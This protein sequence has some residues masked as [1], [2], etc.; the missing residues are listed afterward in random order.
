MLFKDYKF[1]YYTEKEIINPIFDDNPAKES[2]EQMPDIIQENLSKTIYLAEMIN[3]DLGYKMQHN[4]NWRLKEKN[5]RPHKNG[6]GGDFQWFND[7]KYGFKI[8]EF[9]KKHKNIIFHNLMIKGFRC[10][11]ECDIDKKTGEAKG[12]GWI[13]IDTNYD[14]KLNEYKLRIGYYD[15]NKKEYV[16]IPFE[17]KAPYE[18]IK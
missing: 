4:S 5:G 8:F 10:F 1:K 12:N 11:W 16:Y 9:L 7:K 18:Y 15:K 6:N 17:G 2:W 14:V 3:D 13:H